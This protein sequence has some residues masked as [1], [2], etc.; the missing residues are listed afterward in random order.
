MAMDV[1]GAKGSLKADINVTPLVD[2]MLV[3]LIIMM[4]IAP[5]LDQYGAIALP[6]AGNST[7]KPNTQGQTVVAIDSRSMFYVNALPVAPEQP[8]A[9]RAAR[10][11]GQE[12]EAGLREGRQGR[13]VLGDHGRHGRAPQGR[14]SSTSRSSPSR[15]RLQAA[16]R[17]D[18]GGRSVHLRLLNDVDWLA[19]R[20]SVSI[21]PSVKSS[22]MGD[23]SSSLL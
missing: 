17:R 2:V 12:G 19:N 9:A 14:R 21:Q 13:E 18:E 20:S 7:E 15:S 3:L 6:E 10:A 16:V 5:M 4:L 11:R 1:G 23:S 22:H 8:R